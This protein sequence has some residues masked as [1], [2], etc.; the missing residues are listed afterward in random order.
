[1]SIK[2]PRFYNWMKLS[3]TNGAY[4]LWGRFENNIQP[5]DYFIHINVK[6]DPSVFEAEKEILVVGTVDDHFTTKNN[7][8]VFITIV[9][10]III[11]LETLFMVIFKVRKKSPSVS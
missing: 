2:D 4:K 6:F 9:I 5:G 11:F 7:L 1:M 3:S 10:G 8:I